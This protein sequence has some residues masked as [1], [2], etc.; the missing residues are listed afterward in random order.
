MHYLVTLK[1]LS[2]YISSF[3]NLLVICQDFRSVS[4]VGA[5]ANEQRMEQIICPRATQ[6]SWPTDFSVLGN[7][8]YFSL[9][10]YW[11]TSK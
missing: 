1:L 8:K 3:H 9:I 4:G 10:Y 6:R 5:R 11:Q 7:N 2:G